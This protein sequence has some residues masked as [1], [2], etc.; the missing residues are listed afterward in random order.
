M[1]VECGPM[2]LLVQGWQDET[3]RGE[4]CLATAK[5]SIEFLEQVACYAPKF[6]SPA[7]A[8]DEP[9]PRL[10]VVHEMWSAARAVRAPDLT[11]MAAVAGAIADAVADELQQRLSLTKIIV[12]NGGDIAVRLKN[13]ECI[14]AAIRSRVDSPHVSHSILI[15]AR[16]NVGGICTSG[17]GGRSATR[18]IASAVTVLA[19]RASLAD[20][21]A[22]AIANST[23]IKSPSIKRAPARSIDPG[24]DLGDFD[25]TIS[26]GRLSEDE[27]FRSLTQSIYFSE[28]LAAM[29][30]IFGAVIT[31]Q[32]RTS[33]TKKLE[34]L[35]EEM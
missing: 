8:L 15:E 33:W 11:P 1:F 12:N 3:P 29:N 19:E 5:K 32:D 27:V 35:I 2:R 10:A 7:C 21:A 17:L 14:K 16:T 34:G 23:F 20:A 31:V 4:D 25:I 26:V 13:T 22:T 30:K 24:S 6:R 28:A 9:D 18:G